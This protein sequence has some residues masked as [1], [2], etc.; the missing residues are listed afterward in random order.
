[1]H[2]SLTHSQKDA[3]IYIYLKSKTNLS[4]KKILL[5]V[6]NATKKNKVQFLILIADVDIM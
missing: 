6:S 4:C 5:P 3:A 2:I 1:M